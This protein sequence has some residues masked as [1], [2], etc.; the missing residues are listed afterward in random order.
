MF[1]MEYNSKGDKARIKLALK[2][3]FYCITLPSYQW[4]I[5]RCQWVEADLR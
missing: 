2:I 4:I 3:C 5:R 1:K